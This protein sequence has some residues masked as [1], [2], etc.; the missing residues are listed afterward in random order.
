MLLRELLFQFTVCLCFSRVRNHVVAEYYMTLNL[1]TAIRKCM[2]MVCPDTR[3]IMLAEV[4][5]TRNTTFSQNFIS[6]LLHSWIFF[7]QPNKIIDF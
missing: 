6:K 4:T 1:R 3:C 2:H 5:A 7:I